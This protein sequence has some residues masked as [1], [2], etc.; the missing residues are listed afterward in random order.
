MKWILWLCCDLTFW[1]PTW[2]SHCGCWKQGC[3]A[4]FTCLGVFM[5][6]VRFYCFTLHFTSNHVCYFDF[7]FSFILGFTYFYLVFSLVSFIRVYPFSSSLTWSFTPAFIFYFS[8]CTIFSLTFFMSPFTHT[9]ISCDFTYFSLVDT[10]FNAPKPFRH[11]LNDYWALL[12][13]F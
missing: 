13:Y 10:I 1:I 12:T 7:Y 4:P 3:T 5:L 2:I 8:I 9:S 6:D 11:I